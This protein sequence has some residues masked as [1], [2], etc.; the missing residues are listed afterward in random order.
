MVQG[1]AGSVEGPGS[2]LTEL[3]Q[4]KH[5]QWLVWPVANPP[6]FHCEV[7][8]LATFNGRPQQHL[9]LSP[10]NLEIDGVLL[11]ARYPIT[12]FSRSSACERFQVPSPTRPPRALRQHRSPLSE[13]HSLR[14][15][16]MPP[17]LERSILRRPW[18]RASHQE[19][20]SPSSL[21]AQRRR[22]WIETC[23][24]VKFYKPITSAVRHL[25]R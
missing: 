15:Y 13:H 7:D 14:C 10:V 1:L 18:R 8:G 12:R 9:P 5:C 23:G 11:P 19:G 17:C 25:E 20:W 2:C 3:E 6:G 24:N 21:R 22:P 16:D 4:F